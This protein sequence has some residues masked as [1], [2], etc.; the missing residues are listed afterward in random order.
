MIAA[1]IQ[2][3]RTRPERERGG[4]V[5]TPRSRSGLEALGAGSKRPA[6]TLLEVLVALAV[7]LLAMVV[8]GDMVVRNSQ[9]ARDIERQNLA[10]RLCK[11]KLNEVIAGVV[12]LSS[13]G[14]TPFDE[15][16]DYTWSLDAE[17]GSVDGLWNVT[18]HVTRTQTDADDPIECSVTQMILDPTI[19]GSTQDTIPVTVSTDNTNGT[20]SS[21][22]STSSSSTGN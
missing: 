17:N 20:A 7:F 10:T 12:P 4:L 19:E 15:A 1:S 11:S 22:S 13:Q 18:V 6:L 21:T 3:V 5:K 8:F 9:I 16:P 2:C 14:D